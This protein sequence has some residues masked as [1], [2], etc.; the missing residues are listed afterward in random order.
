MHATLF[1]RCVCL[2]LVFTALLTVQGAAQTL[3][4]NPNVNSRPSAQASNLP[5]GPVIDGEVLNDELW[6]YLP[7]I[8]QFIQTK[9]NAGYHA[10]EKT[11]VRIGYTATTFFLSVICF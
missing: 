7:P 8:D 5:E 1:I 3:E 11:E 10:S 6:K 2:Q 9:P 4:A